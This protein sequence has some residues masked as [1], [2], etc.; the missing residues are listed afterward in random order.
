MVTVDFVHDVAK[1]DLNDFGAL[2]AFFIE[3]IRS[4]ELDL[5]FSYIIINILFH[6][7]ID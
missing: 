1:V 7:N 5:L 3:R 6:D 4:L 2:D